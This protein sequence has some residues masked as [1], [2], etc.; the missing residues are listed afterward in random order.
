MRRLMGSSQVRLY[1]SVRAFD[2]IVPSAYFELLKSEAAADAILERFLHSMRDTPP[3]WTRLAERVRAAWPRATLRIWRYEDYA[4]DPRP[5][6][7]A[8]TGIE[9]L[10]L[11]DTPIPER[12]RSPSSSA[13][14]EVRSLDPQLPKPERRERV[15]EIFSRHPRQPGEPA[16]QILS[17]DEAGFLREI[18]EADM[19]HLARRFPGILIT[20]ETP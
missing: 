15:R 14:G 11:A 18:Y 10:A 6:L 13:L 1:L 9:N 8:L 2:G 16:A 12:T 17:A 4:A 20:P 5:I 19:A 3:S 7:R